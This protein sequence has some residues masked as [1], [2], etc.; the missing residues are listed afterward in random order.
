[1][2]PNGWEISSYIRWGS[3]Y[4]QIIRAMVTL[5]GT[6]GWGQRLWLGHRNCVQFNSLVGATVSQPRL[7]VGPLITMCRQYFW[8]LLLS[9][10]QEQPCKSIINM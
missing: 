3:E 4:L 5:L 1:M 7:L 9:F 10:P 8:L 2:H 6:F